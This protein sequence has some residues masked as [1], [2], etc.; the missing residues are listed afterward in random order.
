M[1]EYFTAFHYNVVREL[2]PAR[3]LYFLVVQFLKDSHT[4]IHRGL[5]EREKTLVVTV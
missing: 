4:Y 3:I 5:N 2:N 1:D